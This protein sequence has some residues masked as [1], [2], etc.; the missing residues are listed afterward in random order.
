M[1]EHTRVIDSAGP[2]DGRRVKGGQ[3]L[4]R[5]TR[6]CE[7]TGGIRRASF[8]LAKLALLWVC[9][10]SFWLWGALVSEKWGSDWLCLGSFGFAFVGDNLAFF[11]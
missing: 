7:K 6:I 5:K 2:P 9:L 10:G 4:W 1:A 8:L 11:P 3:V